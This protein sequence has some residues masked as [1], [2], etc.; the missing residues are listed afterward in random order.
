VSTH[1]RWTL[2]RP[3]PRPMPAS[4][5]RADPNRNPARVLSVIAMASIAAGAINLAAAAT[6]GPSNGQYLAFFTVVGGAQVAWAAV[7]L[8][9]AARWWLALGA[10]GNLVVVATWVVSRTAGL[11][12]G[13]VAG[14]TL[15]AHF[16]DSLATALEAVIVIGAAVLV[17]W[18]QGL[19][20][21]AA[22]ALGVT[23]AAA[24]VAGALTIGGVL[25]QAGAFSS[26]PAGHGSGVTGPSAPGGGS[27]GG[28]SGGG[29]GSG[30]GTSGG[31]S[32]G[33]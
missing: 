30:G 23:V 10:A 28:T 31:G 33:Y 17:A 25:S 22:R 2:T 7:S 27:G 12:F 16:A 20:R 8:A 11:P 5:S 6:I 4:G 32:Y 15:P 1:T 24:V 13:P 26:S 9:W 19:A 14:V 29:Y 3:A 21:S 18:G